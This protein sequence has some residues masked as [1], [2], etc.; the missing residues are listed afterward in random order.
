MNRWA[1]SHWM[2][3]KPKRKK[4]IFG[5][6]FAGIIIFL[7][8]FFV[9]ELATRMFIRCIFRSQKTWL[10]EEKR[11][12]KKNKLEKYADIFLWFYWTKRR[13][14]VHVILVEYGKYCGFLMYRCSCWHLSVHS[15]FSLHHVISKMSTKR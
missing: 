5:E 4:K 2:D 9:I 8:Q 12:R 13:W 1:C 15:F 14:H 10:N 7:A 11:R 3:V 6:Y